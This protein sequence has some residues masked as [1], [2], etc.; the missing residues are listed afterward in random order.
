LEGGI[1]GGPPLALC[2]V[3]KAVYHVFEASSP[4][5]VAMSFFKRRRIRSFAAVAAVLLPLLAA[6]YL[7]VRFD[8]EIEIL[9]TGHYSMVFDGYI[10]AL[11]LYDDLRKNKVKAGEEQK[12]VEIVL[13]DFK[14]DKGT[15]QIQYFKQGVFKIQWQNEGDL[16]AAK[17]VT[18]IRRNANMLSLSYVESS[19]EMKVAGASISTDNAKLLT[20]AGLGMDGELRVITDAKVLAHNATL[21]RDNP[22]KGARYKTYVWKIVGFQRSPSLVIALR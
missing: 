6:C 16:L 7:P 11:P 15:K 4:K 19:G 2:P 9:R 20:Q 17:M 10:A 22:A 5:A 1:G 12:R 3:V 8:A 18:F 13:T 14:R 21:V